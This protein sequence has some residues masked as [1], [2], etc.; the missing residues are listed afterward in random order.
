MTLFYVDTRCASCILPCAQRMVSAPLCGTD[1][2]MRLDENPNGVGRK[3]ISPRW[4][5]GRL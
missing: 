4:S 5:G 1:R 2:R 3:Q